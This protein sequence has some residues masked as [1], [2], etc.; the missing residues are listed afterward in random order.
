MAGWFVV[1]T[2]PQRELFAATHL[3]EFAPYCPLFKT[4]T[5]KIR[6]LFPSYLFCVAASNWSP[7]KNT[8]GVRS[9]MMDGD[10][11]AVIPDKDVKAWRDKEVGGL[12]QVPT[13]ARFRSGQR[14]V[15]V[16]GTLRYRVV[17]HTGMS[18]RDRENVLLEMLGSMIRINIASDDLV[19]ESEQAARNSLRDRRE[20][21]NRQRVR[22]IR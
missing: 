16:R 11:P 6:P 4:A 8:M 2:N 9:V 22:R 5:G 18:A 17:I 13:P 10:F 21:L 19:S 14:L 7:I 1:Q 12:V 3:A 20:T 15:V